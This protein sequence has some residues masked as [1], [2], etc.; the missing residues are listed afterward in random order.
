[1]FKIKM[2]SRLGRCRCNISQP[3]RH[4]EPQRHSAADELYCVASTPLSAGAD[5]G[6]VRV[7]VYTNASLLSSAGV[8]HHGLLSRKSLFWRI[9]QCAQWHAR[10]SKLHKLFDVP[11]AGCTPPGTLLARAGTRRARHACSSDEECSARG[12]ACLR[13]HWLSEPEAQDS[14]PRQALPSPTTLAASFVVTY[15]L[16]VSSSS[17]CCPMFGLLGDL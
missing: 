5:D 6:Y 2:S 14:E 8:K 12:R 11:R 9:Q 17:T 10:K 7:L 15:Y 4:S 3:Q 1:M 13:L 16:H